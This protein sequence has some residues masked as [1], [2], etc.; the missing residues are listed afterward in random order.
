MSSL[1]LSSTVDFACD[2]CGLCCQN[3]NRS[4]IYSSLHD[5]DGI[6]RYYNSDTHLCTIYDHRPI[7][8]K[9]SAFAEV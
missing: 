2:K 4:P 6:C 7:I 9:K 3:L 5:G 1:E 8:C